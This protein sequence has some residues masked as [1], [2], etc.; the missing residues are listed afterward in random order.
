LH[1]AF[2][3]T[4]L[5]GIAAWSAHTLSS[6]AAPAAFD[7]WWSLASL[8][9]LGV[10]A[11]LGRATQQSKAPKP[12]LDALCT[13]LEAAIAVGW[14]RMADASFAWLAPFP[15]LLVLAHWASGG[16]AIGVLAL[17][18]ASIAELVA[19]PLEKA[20][21]GVLACLAGAWIGHELTARARRHGRADSRRSR[22]RPTAGDVVD[23]KY[24]LVRRIGKGG[25]GRVYEALRISDEQRLAIKVLHP[26]LARLG[27]P[28][29]RFRREVAV[30]KRLP[31]RHVVR[32]F[33][34]G[35]GGPDIEY[36]AMELLE[37]EDL[38]SRLRRVRRLS[39]DDTVRIAEQLTEVLTAAAECGVVHRD[40]KPR[41][42]FLTKDARGDLEVRLLDFGI[43]RLSDHGE[44]TNLTRS[45][46]IVGTPGF[47][48]PEQI[49]NRFGEIGPHT[50][51]FALGCVVYQCL[52]GYRP[53]PARDP[54]RAVYEVLNHHPRPIRELEPDLPEPV[55]WVLAIALAKRP[56]ERYTCAQEFANDF[57]AAACRNAPPGLAER[58]QALLRP[59]TAVTSTL[60][61]S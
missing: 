18:T 45:G 5:L 49:S 11:A 22:I 26:E 35:S 12:R 33:D 51:V 8:L 34:V 30:T 14:L 24:T 59:G 1:L 48:A 6:S 20:L 21:A 56:S 54:A 29:L 52:S 38:A 37:G 9:G 27:E 60:T 28:V 31:E 44:T 23:G 4:G 55:E 58:G 32:I 47:L 13:G 57:A 15:P 46:K 61:R 19:L 7:R 50:D 53:F 3:V 2:A 25:M 17:A 42:I 16:R 39:C 36:I 41:N 43:C 40:V 10:I